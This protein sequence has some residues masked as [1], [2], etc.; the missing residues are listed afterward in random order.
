MHVGGDIDTTKDATCHIGNLKLAEFPR[1]GLHTHNVL[2]EGRDEHRSIA[3]LQQRGDEGIIDIESLTRLHLVAAWTESEDVGTAAG[4]PHRP[5]VSLFEVHR[6]GHKPLSEDVKARPV[7][8]GLHHDIGGGEPELSVTIAEDMGHCVLRL[9]SWQSLDGDLL[10]LLR[11]S[12]IHEDTLHQGG[13]PQI[14]LL[15]HRHSED[16]GVR[17][18]TVQVVVATSELLLIIIVDKETLVVGAHPD[19]LSGILEDLCD[20]SIRCRDGEP[21]IALAHHRMGEKV[22]LEKTVVGG[23]QQDGVVVKQTGCLHRTAMGQQTRRHL[24]TEWHLL[25][26]LRIEDEQ[27]AIA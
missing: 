24:G 13:D 8:T 19:V 1:L 5:V 16:G 18:D 14:L 27:C 22:H 4:C 3:E 7:V 15:V 20:V 12:M 25:A 26:R 10:G 17:D 6:H 23:T 11:G 9:T 2:I 21:R